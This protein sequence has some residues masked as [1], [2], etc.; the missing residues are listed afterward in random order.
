MVGKTLG[1]YEAALPTQRLAAHPPVV[2]ACG[3]H[4]V[5]RQNESHRILVGGVPMMAW[6]W[7]DKEPG[8][9][10]MSSLVRAEMWLRIKA[11]LYD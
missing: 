8:R 6:A 5:W 7:H 1:H 3:D 4:Q 9:G 2:F 10:Q 11:F